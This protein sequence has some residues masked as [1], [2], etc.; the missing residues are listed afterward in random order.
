MAVEQITPGWAIYLRVSD[1]D[2]QTPERSFAMQRQ[3]NQE[4]PVQSI[5]RLVDTLAHVIE[6]A[7]WLKIFSGRKFGR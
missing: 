2:K 6:G 1:E 3:R 5:G 4:A 7:V